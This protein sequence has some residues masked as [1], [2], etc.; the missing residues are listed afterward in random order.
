VD[1]SQEKI[2]GR[3]AADSPPGRF[4]TLARNRELE[5]EVK[6][7]PET[8]VTASACAVDHQRASVLARPSFHPAIN[9]YQGCST[10][11]IVLLR[12]LEPRYLGLSPVW[13]SVSSS[14]LRAS[15]SE[16]PGGLSAAPRP[17]IF[18]CDL[19]TAFALDDPA[20]LEAGYIA[21]AVA[22]GG[23][24]RRSVLAELRPAP[25]DIAGRN[26]ELGNDSGHLERRAVLQ[27]DLPDHVARQVLRIVRDVGHAVDLAVGDLRIA[28]NSQQVLLRH[29][30]R[31]TPRSPDRGPSFGARASP[32]QHCP[33]ARGLPRDR[34]FHHVHQALED[35]VGVG[36][37]TT[38]LSIARQ[39]GVSKARCRSGCSRCVR[40][41]P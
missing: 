28:E 3:G 9:P 2:K 25:F 20:L 17:L 16:R 11:C 15:V 21:R 5:T 34:A 38:C 6:S 40:A 12:A 41:T 31:S 1:R 14:R 29:A 30:L 35:A 33:I 8:V 39:V 13:T 27:P 19:S 32:A 23:E 7:K 37:M 36:P 24:H 26:R 22:L 10:A 4:E 18:S